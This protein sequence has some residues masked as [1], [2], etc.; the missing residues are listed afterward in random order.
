[1]MR[2]SSLSSLTVAI[3]SVSAYASSG[4]RSPHFVDCVDRCK[5]TRC[6]PNFWNNSSWALRVTCWSCTDDCNYECMHKITDIEIQ[7]GAR[8]QQYYGKWPF[9]RM[10]GMQE[11]ASVAF[12]L[13]NLCVHIRGSSKIR[14]KVP[15]SHPMRPY[16]LVWSI[17]NINSWIWSSVFHTRGDW[18]FLFSFNI[19]GVLTIR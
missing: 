9:W 10:A 18:R 7:A 15:E 16:Y 5:V 13:L 2:L 8:I 11:P 17:I 3:L 14:K 6:G 1:M 12:S 19:R 4:D